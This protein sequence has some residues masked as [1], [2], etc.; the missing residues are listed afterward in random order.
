MIPPTYFLAGNPVNLIGVFD[1]HLIP[2]IIEYR[3][4]RMASRDGHISFT[5]CMIP[6]GVEEP[7]TSFD[8]A[9]TPLEWSPC[10]C[11]QSVLHY[12]ESEPRAFADRLSGETPIED[13]VI[14][15]HASA[16]PR[17]GRTRRMP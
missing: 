3:T 14:L 16:P 5:A 1:H 7:E 11:A 10:D 13:P 4:G 6:I 8:P 15:A 17:S 12:V 9:G 2:E